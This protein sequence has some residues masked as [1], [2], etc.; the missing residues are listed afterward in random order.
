MLSD[1]TDNVGFLFLDEPVEDEASWTK[2]MKGDPVALLTT[3]PAPTWRRP[4]G[5][6]PSR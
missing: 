5:A 4:T 3:P 2:A 1:I 6:T